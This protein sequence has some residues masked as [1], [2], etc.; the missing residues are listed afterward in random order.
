[1]SKFRSETEH[2]CCLPTQTRSDR[3]RLHLY[4]NGQKA[5]NQRKK[6]RSGNRNP[7]SNS[8]LTL[9]CVTMITPGNVAMSVVSFPIF[10][11]SSFFISCSQC[12]NVPHTTKCQQLCSRGC[13]LN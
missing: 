11:T 6:N 10:F 8:N 12:V 7:P 13:E 9:D 4:K 5:E 3:R 2:Q 1:M